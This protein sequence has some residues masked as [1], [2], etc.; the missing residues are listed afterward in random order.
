M[1]GTYHGRC[2]L[3][4]QKGR[5]LPRAVKSRGCRSLSS[6]CGYG[7]QNSARPPKSELSATV[8]GAATRLCCATA[9]LV[10]A[11]RPFDLPGASRRT[12]GLCARA[13]GGWPPD[14]DL[15]P[16]A[17]GSPRSWCFPRVQRIRGT[18]GRDHAAFARPVHQPVPCVALVSPAPVRTRR[19]ANLAGIAGPGL[20]RGSIR[21]A[22]P[23]P[24]PP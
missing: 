23:R 2:P 24:R 8:I 19:R 9:R 16:C 15:P 6:S 12:G 1:G 3:F 21:H 11:P 7:R 10:G 22:E 20:L 17:A 18:R 13:R 5:T 14:R 4:R